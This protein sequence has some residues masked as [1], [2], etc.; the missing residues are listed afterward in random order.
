MGLKLGSRLDVG[1]LERKLRWSPRVS[2]AYKSSPKGQFSLAYGDFYQQARPQFLKYAPSLGSEH[3]RHL[4][5]NYQY[6]DDGRTF[7]AELYW[8]TYRD[9]V[10]FNSPLPL[11]DSTYDNGGYGYAKGLDLFLEG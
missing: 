2:M 11:F 8:K 4:L 1:S 9:L 3:A 5:G 6:L 10:R 7:R